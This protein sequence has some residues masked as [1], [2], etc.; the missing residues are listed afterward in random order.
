M[1]LYPYQ[2]RVKSLIQAGKSVVLQAP[3][4]AG[5]T[6][7]ALAPFIES[8]FDL[9]AE[10]SPR[11]CLYVV[12]MRVL[13]HQFVAEYQEYAAAYQ[14]V[15]RREIKVTIQT[16]DLPKDR[17]FEGDLV[18]CTVDQFLSSFLAMPYSLPQRLANLNAGAMAGAYV[19]CDEFHLLDPDSTLPSVLYALKQLRALAPVLVMTAT[20]SSSMLGALARDLGAEV[21]LVPPEEARAIEMRDGATALRQ[22]VWRVAGA[23]LTAEAVLTEHHARSLALCNTVQGAQALYRDLRHEI[24]MRGLNVDLL[25]L[26]SRFLPEDRST[27]ETRLRQCFGQ[28]ASTNGS[29]IAVAT[30]AI[31]VGVDI[32]CER[33]H[34]ELAPASALIQRAGRCARYPG[35]QGQVTVYPVER[36]VPYGRE[37]SDSKNDPA[38]VK[39]M[40]SAWEWLRAHNGQAFDFEHEQALVSAVAAPHDQA[41]LVGLAAGAPRHQEAIHR[42]LRGERQ[43][44][45]SRLLVRDADSRLVLIHPDPDTLLHNPYG[46]TGFSLQRS[47]LH[48]MFAQWQE[49]DVDV[50]WRVKRL[51]EDKPA[52]EEVG[53]TDYGWKNLEDKELLAAANVLVVHPALAGYLPDEGFVGDRGDTG[54]VS[55]LPPDAAAHTW[56][57][58]R[59]RLESYAEHVRRVLE[60]FSDLALPELRFAAPALEQAAGWP[61]GSVT[62]AAWLACLFHDVGKLSQGWQA[63]AH[64]YQKEIGAPIATTFA[65]AHTDSDPANAQH[66]AAGK[67]VRPRKPNHAGE[68]ALA[69]GPI[70][71]QALEG[72][73]PLVRATLTAMARHHTPFA[74]NAAPYILEAQAGAQIQATLEFLPKEVQSRT[75]LSRL[76]VKATQEQLVAIIRPEDCYGWLAYTQVVRALRRADQEGTARGSKEVPICTKGSIL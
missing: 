76:K 72:N 7:A 58:T 64:A 30:Q 37:A 67:T 73:E 57:G 35:E 70:L 5:K 41:V 34:T 20:F 32:T 8:F 50:D 15:H 42:M 29:I 65:A 75:N 74:E 53:Q 62:R 10:T 47:T 12:P 46:A 9:P 3:T 16:G 25:L 38:W 22:R 26:H 56:E 24:N 48:G 19:V 14:R 21:E 63:W 36:Y 60:A 54:F 61:A 45:D 13:A 33:L 17:R 49:R 6:R 4:G 23:P 31:E 43:S 44:G 40:K 27:I 55:T 18:F 68:S 71:V 52:S 66:K 1:A 28:G 51:I 69:V 59:Y 2:E 39:E 11:K